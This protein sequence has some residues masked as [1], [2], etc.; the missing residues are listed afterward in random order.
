M[1]KYFMA[2]KEFLMNF[3][4]HLDYAPFSLADLVDLV[5]IDFAF[6]FFADVSHSP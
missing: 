6:F 2:L 4:I 5:A 3:V 1:T